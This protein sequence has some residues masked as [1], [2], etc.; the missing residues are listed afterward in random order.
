VRREDPVEPMPG[1]HVAYV[2]DPDGNWIELW[3]QP[4]PMPKHPPETY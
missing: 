2:T 4:E 1:F 3:Q